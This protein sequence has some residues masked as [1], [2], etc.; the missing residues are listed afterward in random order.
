MVAVTAFDMAGGVRRL[1]A[2]GMTGWKPMR[3][4]VE[5]RVDR[6]PRD[7]ANFSKNPLH[8]HLTNGLSG[9]GLEMSR[10]RRRHGFAAF[11]AAPRWTKGSSQI[12][13]INCIWKKRSDCRL[14]NFRV[15]FLQM[16]Q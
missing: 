16:T 11:V 12:V 2:L 7:I 9:A 3:E 13:D 5:V 15:I 6:P 8:S 14:R 1:A 10:E 4:R